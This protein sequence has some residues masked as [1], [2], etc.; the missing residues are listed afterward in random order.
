MRIKLAS[1]RPL[2]YPIV[3]HGSRLGRWARCGAARHEHS[4]RV[5]SPDER[6][7]WRSS[8]LCGVSS[9]LVLFPCPRSLRPRRISHPPRRRRATRWCPT[10]PHSSRPPTDSS[11]SGPAS[12]ARFPHPPTCLS[13]RIVVHSSCRIIVSYYS[14]RF[15]CHSRRDSPKIDHTH[16]GRSYP[17]LGPGFRLPRPLATTPQ[18][19]CRRGQANVNACT[20][21]RYWRTRVDVRALSQSSR[22]WPL[23]NSCPHLP[24]PLPCPTVAITRVRLNNCCDVDMTTACDNHN[25]DA[26][27]PISL[28]LPLPHP[29]RLPRL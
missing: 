26:L 28:P 3:L 4:H 23:P 25:D 24:S 8:F 2:K 17:G 14:T 5:A 9:S 6:D 13:S 16:G 19:H 7:T 10:H 20:S 18:C 11:C 22:S 27:C 29:H 12:A 1:D 15:P 21:T